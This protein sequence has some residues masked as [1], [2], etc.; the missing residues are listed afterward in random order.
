[1]KYWKRFL[2]IMLSVLLL[3]SSFPVE[4]LAAESKSEK[5][6]ITTETKIRKNDNYENSSYV[7]TKFRPKEETTIKTKVNLNNYVG[8]LSYDADNEIIGENEFQL[9]ISVK[10]PKGIDFINKDADSIKNSVSFEMST[11]DELE[12]PQNNPQDH[13]NTI[14]LSQDFKK[15]EK[16]KEFLSVL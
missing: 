1:M 15:R 11:Y 13:K 14:H 6:L 10:L 4:L 7:V 9:D 3:L 8:A 12:F 2:S 16:Y 5:M